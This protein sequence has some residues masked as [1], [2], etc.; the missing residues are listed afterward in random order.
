MKKQIGI[1]LAAILILL[2]DG[3]SFQLLQYRKLTRRRRTLPEATGAPGHHRRSGDAGCG[4][5]RPSTSAPASTPGTPPSTMIQRIRCCWPNCLPAPV[6]NAEE[7]YLGMGDHR[8]ERRWQQRYPAPL[9]AGKRN[10]GTALLLGPGNREIPVCS[11]ITK[12]EIILQ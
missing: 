3:T 8:P 12:S 10:P 9:F 6:E 1:L 5:G 4:A 7:R 2:L 11:V